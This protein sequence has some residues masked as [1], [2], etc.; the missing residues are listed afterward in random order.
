MS[1]AE[2]LNA[3]ARRKAVVL[4]RIATR[5]DQ[6]AAA[7]AALEP[8]LAPIDR[9]VTQWQTLTA[10][11]KRTGAPMALTVA[12]TVASNLGGVGGLLRFVPALFGIRRTAA[13]PR[14]PPAAPPRPAAP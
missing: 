2:E 5:R 4:A 6:C 12:R 13:A 3:L 1:A 7:V 11:A 14:R 8:Q 9:M 10:E